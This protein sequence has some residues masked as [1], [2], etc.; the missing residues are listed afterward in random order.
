MK[1]VY[2]KDCGDIGL[3]KV[4]ADLTMKGI[5]VALPISE[6]LPFDL[7]AIKDGKLSRVSVKY[8]KLNSKNS[9]EVPMR[10]ISNNAQGYKVKV[11]DLQ[12]VD[13]FAIYCPDTDRVYYVS[14]N[15]LVSYKNMFS[16]RNSPP[17]KTCS[18]NLASDYEDV[19]VIF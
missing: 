15:T 13:A 10:T 7:I 17:S 19:M 14:G 1:S 2:T 4:I 8:R 3:T 9:I 5:K 18:H 16:L 6:H 11:V 12:E